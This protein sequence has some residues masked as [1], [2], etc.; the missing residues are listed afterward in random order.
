MKSMTEVVETWGEP[1][2]QIQLTEDSY[3]FIYNVY[4]RPEQLWVTFGLFS[5][6]YPQYPSWQ[7][8]FKDDEFIAVSVTYFATLPGGEELKGGEW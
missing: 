4:D 8:V 7:S 5:K 3:A 2:K 6:W 1:A